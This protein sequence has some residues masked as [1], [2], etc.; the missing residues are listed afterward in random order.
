MFL[1]N[2]ALINKVGENLPEKCVC[3]AATVANCTSRTLT[4]GLTIATA[5]RMPTGWK[6]TLKR[7]TRLLLLFI[8]DQSWAPA[9]IEDKQDARRLHERPTRK[10]ALDALGYISV[11]EYLRLSSTTFT[12][13]APEAAEF[14]EITQN[15]G[16]FVVQGH[17]RSL[18]LVP[19]ERTLTY[20]LSCIVWFC[21][22]ITLWVHG[23]IR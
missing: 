13:C 4:V 6:R 14:G 22:H 2:D 7:K 8:F 1:W 19:I 12:Q 20:L 9:L 18:I 5:L 21:M 10:R 23:I 17:S 11:A 3:T 16:H 15:M